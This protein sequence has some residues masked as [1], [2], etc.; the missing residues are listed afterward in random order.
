MLDY[1]VKVA[2][3]AVLVVAVT[4]ISKRSTLLGA[5]LAA[6]P[7]TS[8]LAFIWLYWDTGDAVRVANLATSI[9]WLIL[10]SLVFF[11]ALPV[12]IKTGW[13]FWPSLSLSLAITTIAYLAM[14]ALLR[15]LGIGD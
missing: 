14:T 11:I 2:I 8:L 9:L 1:A 15:H 4:E 12:L 7:M 3:T 6:L 10:A 13:A 5:V